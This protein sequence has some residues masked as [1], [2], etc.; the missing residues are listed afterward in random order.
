MPMQKRLALLASVLGLWGTLAW[1]VEFEGVQPAAL[2]QPRVNV[3]L[4]RELK[5]KAL[6]AGKD[7]ED[8]INIQAF[9][10]T[11]ASGVMLS[12]HTADA[13]GVRRE[14]VNSPAKEQN[15]VFKDVGVGGGDSFHVS[16]PLYVFVA[17]YKA[18]GEPDDQ[19]GYSLAFGPVRAQVGP[20]NGGLIEM[21][22]GGLDV[23][24]MP[25]IKGH[26]IIMDPKPVDTFADTMRCGLF[27]PAQAKIP[28]TD[29]HVKL[30]FGDFKRFTRLEPKDATGP[31]ISENPFIGPA[32]A[33]QN[34]GT[35]PVVVEYNGKKLA[36]SFLLDTGAA[37]S[38]ISSKTAE[39]LGVKYT[40]GTEGTDHAH[41]DGVADKDQFMLTIGGVGG[42]H[43]A[44][45]FFMDKLVLP[46]RE[47]DPIIY[48]GAPVLVSDITVE[49]PAAKQTITLDG[50]FGM[51]FMVASALVK[52][53]GLLP[54][55]EHMTAG[56]FEW[57]VIDEPKG[58]LGL[59]VKR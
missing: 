12:G 8:T 6:R 48:K 13:L 30:S 42:M 23:V 46:T 1:A 54:D 20:L 32:P 51:N 4:R 9:L 53:A 11:G 36:A 59:K 39:K 26:I 15:V 25:G 27:A 24:G 7:Q 49:D 47:G 58:E 35:P 10:D 55:I 21:L 37:A 44:A 43:K 50:V 41:L 3:H 17:A 18:G 14:N 33:K 22:T 2:D 34:D 5:G 45:G 56:P 16:E 40:A 52:E 31:A 19:E 38:M 57:I 29:H 28:A